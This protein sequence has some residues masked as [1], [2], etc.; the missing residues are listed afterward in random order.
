[1]FK[2]ILVPTDGSELS[3]DAVKDAIQLAK[4]SGAAIVAVNVQPAY[5]QPIVVETFVI[6]GYSQEQYEADARRRANML[7]ADVKGLA[8]AASVPCKTVS[9]LHPSTYEAIIKTAQDEGCDLIFMA[10]H[11]RRGVAAL[12]LGGETHKVLTHCKIPVLVHR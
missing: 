8:A 10:S 9:V 6:S 5:Q 7:L 3:N 11:G 12:I 2:R 1:M 4:E